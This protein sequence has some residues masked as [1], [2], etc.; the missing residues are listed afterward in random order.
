MGAGEHALE[1]GRFDRL[2]QAGG[3]SPDLRQ[4]F[5]ILRFF[6]QFDHHADILRLTHKSVPH[7]D[8]LFQGRAF[9][10]DVLRLRGVVPEAGNCHDRFDLLDRF[11]LGIYVKET[12]G[13]CRSALHNP[14]IL[15]FLL[16]T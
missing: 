4:G 2:D 12:P 10:Y 8:D 9:L 11:T 6:P 3:H 13:V 16:G 1:L 7:L 14:S 15:L 5:R